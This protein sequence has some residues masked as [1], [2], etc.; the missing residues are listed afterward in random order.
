MTPETLKTEAAELADTL[1]AAF[2]RHRAEAYAEGFEA[3][4]KSAI[5]RV[6]PEQVAFGAAGL[7]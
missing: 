7:P 1:L 4:Q 6:N 2:V 5:E 3:G